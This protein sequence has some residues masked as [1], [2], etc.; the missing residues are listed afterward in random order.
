MTYASW[1]PRH[2]CT[3]IAPGKLDVFVATLIDGRRAALGPVS[4]YDAA[5]AKARAFHRDHPCQVKVLPLT[6]AEARNLLVLA[7]DAAPGADD[8][9]DRKLLSDTLLHVAC[10]SNDPDARRE[11]IDLL[12]QMGAMK[13]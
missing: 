1:E 2:R 8:A 7:S 10:E 3:T 11:A 5:V 9:A 13:P 6:V 4:E 12:T